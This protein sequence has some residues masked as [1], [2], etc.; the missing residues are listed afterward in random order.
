[1]PMGA[2]FNQL[3]FDKHW[4]N[5]QLPHV[6]GFIFNKPNFHG[7]SEANIKKVPSYMWLGLTS[8]LPPNDPDYRKKVGMSI[9]GWEHQYYC[10]KEKFHSP[11]LTKRDDGEGYEHMCETVI[12][13]KICCICKVCDNRMT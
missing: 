9:F 5:I 12:E 4:W 2:W 1:M 8:Q 6:K 7:R 10:T 3:R 11:Y 13:E